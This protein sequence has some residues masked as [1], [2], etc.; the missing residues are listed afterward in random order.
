[1]KKA[2]SLLEIIFVL[3]IIALIFTFAIRNNQTFFSNST[4]SKI[5]SDVALI[6][7][8]IAS[9]VHARMLK[10]QTQFPQRLDDAA[11]NTEGALLF[12]GI[13]DEKLLDY[14]FVSTS[15]YERQIGQWS[16]KTQK[17]YLVWISKEESIEFTYDLN[18]GTF[19]CDYTQNSCKEID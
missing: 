11:L 7:S 9:K 6:R 13:E 17:S 12:S 1:M 16:K 5:K 2:F 10:A 18:K 8:A 14:P 19:E 4:L 15:S 3:V